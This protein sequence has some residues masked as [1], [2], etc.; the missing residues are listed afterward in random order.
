MEASVSDRM[1]PGLATPQPLSGHPP[2]APARDDRHPGHDRYFGSST[3]VPT[4]LASSG[5]STTEPSGCWWFSRIATSQRVVARVP[6]RVAATCGFPLSSRYRM[7][8]RRAWKVVQL[9]VEVSS[10]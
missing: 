10:R 9:E 8:S 3:S 7:D 2:G 6:L 4:N 5:G 1:T